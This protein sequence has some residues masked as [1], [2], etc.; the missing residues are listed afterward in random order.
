MASYGEHDV[1]EY[2]QHGEWRDT[3]A[4]PRF[5]PG[6][7]GGGG[8]GGYGGGGGGISN[9]AAPDPNMSWLVDKF[10][11]R[12]SSDNTQRAIDRSNAA[13]A[14]SA[15]LLGKDAR[16]NLA[17]RGALGSGVGAAYIQK[18]ITEPAQRE[19]AGR[20]ADISMD[21]E[22]RLDA[23]TLGGAGLMAKPAELALQ[24]QGLAL[25]QYNTD[26]QLAMAQS[27]A[28]QA[29]WLALMNSL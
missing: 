23:L 17:A 14:D 28:Q 24:Q 16:A 15:A 7:P 26:A 29:Q 5:V 2:Y 22:R 9:T 18:R 12:F 27:Q 25:N 6:R 20:A 19:A 21:A 3:P 13:I 1:G 10:K 11:D 4:G 8:G